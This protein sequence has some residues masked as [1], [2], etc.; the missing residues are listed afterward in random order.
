LG[1]TSETTPKFHLYFTD[2]LWLLLSKP[3]NPAEFVKMSVWLC[4]LCRKKYV[5]QCVRRSFALCIVIV[6][7]VSSFMLYVNVSKTAPPQQLVY[8]LRSASLRRENCRRLYCMSNTTRSISSHNVTMYCR[9]PDC[10]ICH[11]IDE[12]TQRKL[13][14]V[15]RGRGGGEEGCAA[16]SSSSCLHNFFGA[17]G[18]IHNPSAALSDCRCCLL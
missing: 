7:Q 10:R 3:T 14:H 5:V 15:T 16:R 1:D 8:C 17:D 11:P 9:L 2:V 13:L 12:W 18:C 4:S 6:R